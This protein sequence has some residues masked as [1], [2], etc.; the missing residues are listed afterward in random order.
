[1][2]DV[3]KTTFK[4]LKK[5]S[6]DSSSGL[7]GGGFFRNLWEPEEGNNNFK[8]L[9]EMFDRSEIEQEYLQEI[10]KESFTFFDVMKLQM[11]ND[12]VAPVHRDMAYRYSSRIGRML[13]EAGRREALAKNKTGLI[14]QL[15]DSILGFLAT[16]KGQA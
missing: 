7:S 16:R 5:A 4:V 14:S 13:H 1:M 8:E 2:K 11:Q 15:E 9:A 10:A 3:T 12:A 6:E